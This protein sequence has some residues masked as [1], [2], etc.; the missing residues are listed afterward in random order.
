MVSKSML[1]HIEVANILHFE[2]FS[3]TQNKTNKEILISLY[4][5][6]VF[7]CQSIIDKLEN[8]SHLGLAPLRTALW[9]YFLV[10]VVFDVP[11]K[12]RVDCKISRV[13]TK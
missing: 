11:Y 8:T 10:F 7:D 12:G 2:I 1:L 13:L 5:T 4:S 6:A 9:R 3:E